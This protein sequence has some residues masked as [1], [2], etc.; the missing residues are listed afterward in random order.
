MVHGPEYPHGHCIQTT[1]N[2]V[3]ISMN[4]TSNKLHHINKQVGLIALGLSFVHFKKLMKIQL[5]KFGKT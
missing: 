5:L 1:V 3:K 2:N 4:T